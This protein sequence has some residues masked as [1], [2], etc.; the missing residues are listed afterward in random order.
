MIDRPV[1]L[2]DDDVSFLR[3]TARMLRASGY[4]VRAHASAAEFFEQLGGAG[5]GC[6]VTDLE[7]PGMDGLAL[8]DRLAALGS[9]MSVVFLTG[10][11]SIPATVTAMKHGAEDF[12]TK[13]APREELLAAVERALANAAARGTDHARRAEIRRRFDALSPRE[14]EVLEHVVRGRLNKQT[15]AELGIH[16]R[17]VKLHRTS[18]TTKLGVHSAPELALLARDAGL[19]ET[20]ATFPKG[21]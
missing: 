6:V 13:Q 11:G 9:S 7:M 20:G 10:R 18:I 15:A 2:V 16:E 19:F 17:T 8:L 14:L 5:D 12:L 4:Q 3:A 21:Q 1:H